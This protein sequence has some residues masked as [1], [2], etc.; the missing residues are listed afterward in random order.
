MVGVDVVYPRDYLPLVRLR[1]EAVRDVDAAHHQHPTL[2][3]D[4]AGSLGR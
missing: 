3:L 4:F 2:Q 1:T